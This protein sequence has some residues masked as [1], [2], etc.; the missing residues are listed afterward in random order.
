[1]IGSKQEFLGVLR[2][3]NPWWGGGRTADLP[4]WRRAAFAPIRAWMQSPPAG[5]ALLLS[6]ARQV[7]KTTLFLQAI[8]LLLER[9]VPAANI[10]YATLDHPLFKQSG[11]DALIQV[12]REFEPPR[13]GPEYVFLDEV[14]QARDWQVW[15]KHQIDFE[16]RRRIAVT[17]SATPLV[18]EGQ[19]SGVGRWQTIRLSTMSFYE[20]LQ[21]RRLQA[22]VAPIPDLPSVSS[23]R[24]LQEWKATDF[25][26]V[27]SEARPLL[28]HFH[29]YLLRGGFPQCALIE[30]IPLAQKLLREDIVDKVLKRD[31]TAIFGVRRVIE[32]EQVFLYL[33]LHD[34]GLLDVPQLCQ[35]LEA[36][37]TT[38]L[39]YI[40]LL[41][42][43][44]LIHRLR[45]LGYGK[46]VLRSRP[47][48]YLADPAISPS[49]LL[50]GMGLLEDA[51]AL[52]R[53]VETA[54]F[55]H[56]YQRYWARSVG[57]SYWR[58]KRDREVDFVA[59]IEGRL[60]PF[61]V[62]YRGPGHTRAGD[63]KGLRAFCAARGVELAYVVTRD[64]EDFRSETIEAPPAPVRML[65][66]PAALA[67]YWL[68]RSE[69][70]A[71]QQREG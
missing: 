49:V 57:F 59:D 39:N 68:G 23:L 11:L 13:E 28:V 52:A 36:K 53:A 70:D 8:D 34:G 58:G 25:T 7:G 24:S 5:R 41:E 6:G 64:L 1:M 19:E 67:C 18:T 29:E 43:A 47:K 71:A 33:C 10:L 60:V 63:L 69:F 37:R 20:H 14:Q 42:A 16:K 61:E 46:Q 4:K 26:R 45:P 55:N 66:I 2:R 50:K 54:C 17:G 32:L 48:V 35:R 31:M 62:K 22:E 9:G 38:V 3:Y 30:S 65:K 51:N 40:D 27:A 12:W 15:I 56:V 44:H 21:L